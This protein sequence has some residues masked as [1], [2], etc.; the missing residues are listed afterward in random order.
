AGRELRLRQEYF[1][2]A[3]SLQ[4]ILARHLRTDGDLHFLPIRA[5]IQ[6]NDTHPSIAVAELMRLLVDIHGLPWSE[7]WRIT[8]GTFSYTNHTV[9]REGC[10]DAG[11]DAPAVMSRRVERADDSGVQAGIAR[12]KLANEVA[13][14][15]L[16][17]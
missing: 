10:V 7:A 4:D 14:A 13:L 6:L 15:R 1:F 11:L 3:A 2:V 12:A 17:A 5:A 8:V 9:L 16:V